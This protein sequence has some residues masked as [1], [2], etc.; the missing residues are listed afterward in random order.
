MTYDVTLAFCDLKV[1]VR[2]MDKLEVIPDDTRRKFP[3]NTCE[4]IGYNSSFLK[5]TLFELLDKEHNGAELPLLT[6]WN[7]NEINKIS[8][9]C[10]IDIIPQD[11]NQ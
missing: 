7:T 3:T 4:V 6:L 1:F 8:T 2:W 11:L 5:C 9:T 10:G